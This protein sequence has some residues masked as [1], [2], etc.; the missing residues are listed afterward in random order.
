MKDMVEM[1]Q[2]DVL[3]GGVVFDREAGRERLIGERARLDAILARATPA[4]GC[5][6]G[7]PVAPARGL[8][9]AVTPHVNAPKP[10]AI[11][12]R[13]DYITQFTGW[14]GFKAS[15]AA[16][17]FDDLDRRAAA[18]TDKDGKPCKSPF[19]RSQVTVARLYRDLVERHDAGGMKCAS[20]EARGGGG[21]S[22]GEFIDAFVA[23]GQAIAWMQKQIGGGVAMSVR[24]VRPSARGQAGAQ[25]IGDRALVD[26]ICLHGRSFRDVL[27]RHGWAVSGQNVK[28]LHAALA[29]ALDRM[30]GAPHKSS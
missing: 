20:M 2:D 6:P 5:G 18:R 1:E 8:Q 27:E 24:R 28:S 11:G 14:E 15:R 16:D 12:R 13:D 26:A 9:V 10:D 21:I 19:T 3:G 22:G 25:I 7:I 4:V 23:E 30:N 29:A 17:I